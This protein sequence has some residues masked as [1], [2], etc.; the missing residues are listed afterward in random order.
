[1]SI[2]RVKKLH[3]H[4]GAHKTATTHFQTVLEI[5]GRHFPEG[6]FYEP[7]S[8][9][10]KRLKWKNEQTLEKPS[11]E[12]LNNLVTDD[13]E[14]LIISEENLIGETKDIFKYPRVYGGLLPRLKSLNF[15]YDQFEKVE[16]WFAIRS[17][18]EYI[19]SMYCEYL[20]HFN[21]RR[22]TDVLNGRLN[23]SWT[24]VVEEIREVFPNSI[25]H[26]I[27]HESYQENLRLV[28]DSMMSDITEWN[29]L[30]DKT[31]RGSVTHQAIKLYGYF[32]SLIPRTLQSKTI[33]AFNNWTLLNAGY[34]FNPLTESEKRD[35]K[36]LYVADLTELAKMNYVLVL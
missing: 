1:M 34:K 13:L 27:P 36:S 5:N 19:P 23:Q 12:Y 10:R 35:L 9:V 26:I 20:R 6:V 3:L 2:G 31:V 11:I 4:L 21:Y 30:K 16:I 8:N 18:D 29:L 32:H 22:F 14:V 33:D 25:I 15:F 17:M 7:M 24:H 28:L